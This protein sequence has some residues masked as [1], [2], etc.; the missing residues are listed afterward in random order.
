[1]IAMEEFDRL[2]KNHSI[3]SVTHDILLG[4]N[5]KLKT[6]KMESDD[7]NTHI[8]KFEAYIGDIITIDMS[9]IDQMLLTCKIDD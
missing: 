4:E 8:R 5:W 2:I 9:D 1:M 7:H 3:R 6:V